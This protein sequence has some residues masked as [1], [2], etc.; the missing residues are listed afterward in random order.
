MGPS[1][2]V[3]EPLGAM[4]LRCAQGCTCERQGAGSCAVLHVG[5]SFPSVQEHSRPATPEFS[6]ASRAALFTCSG[7]WAPE[8]GS[9]LSAL[10]RVRPH[11]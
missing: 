4:G 3:R 2:G 10:G 9:M 5:V 6:P 7:Q 8:A 11:V 1:V